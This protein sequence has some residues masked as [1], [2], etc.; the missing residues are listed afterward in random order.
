MH[1]EAGLRKENNKYNRKCYQ[2]AGGNKLVKH[3]G[4]RKPA[5]GCWGGSEERLQ[6]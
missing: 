5:T 3:T 6:K 2:L 4:S 1:I